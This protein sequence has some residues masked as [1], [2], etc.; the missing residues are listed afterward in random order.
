ME[1]LNNSQTNPD[2]LQFVEEAI[3]HLQKACS[4]SSHLPTMTDQQKADLIRVVDPNNS[5]ERNSQE[6]KWRSNVEA[7]ILRVDDVRKTLLGFV[8]PMVRLFDLIKNYQ[9]LF[10][11]IN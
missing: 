8:R 10:I 11:K 9:A 4:E 5:Q 7:F 2:D 6:R 3:K 1:K